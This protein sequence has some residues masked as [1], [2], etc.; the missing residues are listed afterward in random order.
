MAHGEQQEGATAA[1]AGACQR[2]CLPDSAAQA[3]AAVGAPAALPE[4]AATPPAS[5]P[6]ASI[7]S[8]YLL[9]NRYAAT[10]QPLTP[11]SVPAN[12][13]YRP[14]G[15]DVPGLASYAPPP[16]DPNEVCGCV[17]GVPRSAPSIT[18]VS[19]GAVA[20]PL[21]SGCADR[22][23]PCT[24]PKLR[25]ADDDLLSNTRHSWGLCPARTP[26]CPWTRASQPR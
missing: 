7:T 25:R 11:S 15:P 21:L 19:A 26:V 14:A 2:Q 1:Q 3:P 13:K 18:L 17:A 10:G 9:A 22:P 8:S 16:A 20:S 23:M 24:C 5:S 6:G 12:H 4:Q